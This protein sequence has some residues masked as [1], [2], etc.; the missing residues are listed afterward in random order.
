[1]DQKV[2]LCNFSLISLE[3]ISYLYIFAIGII[4]KSRKAGCP[5]MGYGDLATPTNDSI[6]QIQDTSLDGKVTPSAF[7]FKGGVVKVPFGDVSF[8]G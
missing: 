3:R 8:S 1:M 2:N 5:L 4:R 7:G 6:F